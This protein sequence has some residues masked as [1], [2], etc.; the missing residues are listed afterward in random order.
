MTH[1]TAQN[2]AGLIAIGSIGFLFIC[3]GAALVIRVLRESH[4]PFHRRWRR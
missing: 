1:E 3:I 4:R 2:I